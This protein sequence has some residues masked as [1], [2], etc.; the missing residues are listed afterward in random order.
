M[1]PSDQLV[2]RLD[3]LEAIEA[4]HALKARYAALADAKYTS[5]YERQPVERVAEV[6][7]LQTECFTR[8][9]IWYGGE[10]GGDLQGHDQLFD[11]F[12]RSP[13]C[14]ATHLYASPVLDVNGRHAQATWRLWQMAL[15]QDSAEAVFLFGSTRETYRREDD[16]QWLI[17]TMAFDDVQLMPAAPLP[18]PLARRLS[19]LATVTTR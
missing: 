14:F 4:I 10:F 13:W 8:D 6:A 11:W 16:G 9:A 7:R 1:T 15:R 18:Y 17:A 12:Q 2:E 5:G 3:R 19:D